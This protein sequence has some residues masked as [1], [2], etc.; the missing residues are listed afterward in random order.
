MI[1]NVLGLKD[2][3]K[4]YWLTGDYDIYKGAVYIPLSINRIDAMN[5]DKTKIT[6]KQGKDYET[7]YRGS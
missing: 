5:A 6:E 2:L 3:D 4:P 7:M 1:C